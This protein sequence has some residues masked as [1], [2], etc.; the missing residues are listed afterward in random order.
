MKVNVNTALIQR[1]VP[2][3]LWNRYDTNFWQRKLIL[4]EESLN[5]KKLQGNLYKS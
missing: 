2:T 4:D 5:S 1:Y 3:M